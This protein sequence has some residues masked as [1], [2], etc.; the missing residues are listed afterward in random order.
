MRAADL[1]AEPRCQQSPPGDTGLLQQAG[2]VR[3]DGAWRQVQAPRDLGVCGPGGDQQ[4]HFVL[5]CRRPQRRWAATPH[6]EARDFAKFSAAHKISKFTVLIPRL[7][8]SNTTNVSDT[9]AN[10]KPASNNKY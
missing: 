8:P 4:Q 5:A 9:R 7:W 6:H 10:V 2:D 1:R 3:L